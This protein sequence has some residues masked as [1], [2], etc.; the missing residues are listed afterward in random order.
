MCMFVLSYVIYKL[1]YYMYS[2]YM[3]MLSLDVSCNVRNSVLLT[4]ILHKYIPFENI[5]L[6]IIVPCILCFE[7]KIIALN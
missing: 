6:S 1:Y 3:H 5:S 2:F 7:I 4:E